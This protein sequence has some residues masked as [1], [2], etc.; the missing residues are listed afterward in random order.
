MI[1]TASRACKSLVVKLIADKMRLLRIIAKKIRC[2]SLHVPGA[3]YLVEYP[4]SIT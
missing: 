4:Q 2:I 1:L 3:D